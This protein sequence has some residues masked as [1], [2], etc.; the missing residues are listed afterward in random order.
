MAKRK[1]L[2]ELTIKDNFM[3]GAVMCNEEHCRQLLELILEIPI[4]HVEVSK[5]KKHHLSPRNSFKRWK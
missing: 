3:F 4:E 1:T 5:E 2:Q